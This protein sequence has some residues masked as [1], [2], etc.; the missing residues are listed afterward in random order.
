M[1]AKSNNK[2]TVKCL[3]EMEQY[4]NKY[5]VWMEVTNYSPETIIGRKLILKKFRTWCEDR[6]IKTPSEVSRPVIESYQKHLH[7][8]I[9]RTGE[10]ISV[11]TQQR[12]LTAVRMFFNWLS[13]SKHIPL[14]PTSDLDL[15]RSEYILPKAI[16]SISEVEQILNSVNLEDP[17]G[18]RDRSILETLYSTG[19]RRTELCNL[20]MDSI[21]FDKGL[22]M[23]RQGKYN[24]DRLI[25]IGKRAI[26]WIDKYIWETRKVVAPDP[27]PGILFLTKKGSPLGPKRLSRLTSEHI[28]KS[29]IKKEGACHIFRH[30]MAT[31]M[32]ENG[33]DTRF[34]QQMLG[35]ASLESTQIYTRIAVGKLKDVHTLTHPGANNKRSEKDLD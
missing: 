13:K 6:G 18:V 33:A 32:L 23:I 28:E 30:T 15:P 27:D 11:S 12:R 4:I 7:Y 19:M 21:D 34:I 35:H 20:K 25:P 24:K 16:L 29:G 1:I 26:L 2:S 17:M 8:F 14:N 10:R 9:G 3:S 22:V 5:F 31:L